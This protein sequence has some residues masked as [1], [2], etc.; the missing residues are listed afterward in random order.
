M[1]TRLTAVLP[2]TQTIVGMQPLFF[3]THVIF[4]VVMS[5]NRSVSQ[6]RRAKIRSAKRRQVRRDRRSARRKLRS[7]TLETRQ[8][9]AADS[10]HNEFMPEDVNL[11]GAVTAADA[12]TIINGMA[13]RGRAGND[14]ADVQVGRAARRM[15]DVN[16]DGIESAADALM[17][18]RRMS[19]QARGGDDDVANG[20]DDQPDRNRPDLE[21]PDRDRP[22][23]D[24]PGDQDP[25][26]QQD[27]DI[28]LRVNELFGDILVADTE[29]Q[30]PGYASRAMALLNIAVYDAVA[31]G[32]GN[33]DETFYDS[34]DLSLERGQRL[35]TDALVT[36]AATTVLGQLYPGQQDL[37]DQFLAENRPDNGGSPDR[38]PGND[39][40]TERPDERG[41]NENTDR[42]DANPRGGNDGTVA[43]APSDALP[44][45][46]EMAIGQTIAETLV[47]SRAADGWDNEATFEYG[48]Q[49][50]EFQADPLNPDVPVWGPG[51]GEVD[52]FVISNAQ[53][54]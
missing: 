15:T 4:G 54:Y 30:N 16:N 32:S 52:P 9:L 12:L 18:I 25:Q 49:P 2:A 20:R 27:A 22:E 26:S 46:P 29:N 38:G 11:D 6:N 51:W 17:V 14:G 34:Y 39:R 21:N 3:I 7:E 36:H 48:T 41:G 1:I 31:I 33:A 8:M 23:R 35:N 53:D 13:V 50:G 5:R 37:I 44:M 47:A 28:V 10:F 42:R 24:P 19:Q 40:P 45:R 43:D